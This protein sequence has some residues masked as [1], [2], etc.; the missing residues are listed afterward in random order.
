MAKQE[1]K[2]E[3]GFWGDR[4]EVIYED[5]KKIGETRHETNLFG[6]PRDRTYDTSGNRVSETITKDTFFSGPVSK[7]YDSS[8]N[9]VS[10]TRQENTFFGQRTVIVENGQKIGE[11]KRTSTFIDSLSGYNGR[12][13]IESY[14]DRSINPLTRTASEDNSSPSTGSSSSSYYSSGTRDTSVARREF[15]SEGVTPSPLDIVLSAKEQ[16]ERSNRRVWTKERLMLVLG[17]KKDLSFMVQE[18]KYLAQNSS[19]ELKE[20]VLSIA[21]SDIL[22]KSLLND[23]AV[24]T[25]NDLEKLSEPTLELII[26]QE[27]PKDLFEGAIQRV[28]GSSPSLARIVK[29]KSERIGKLAI[30]KMSYDALMSIVLDSPPYVVDYC[31]KKF[32][33]AVLMAVA[34]GSSNPFER[35]RAAKKLYP[36]SYLRQYLS[37]Q[38]KAGFEEV[39][40]GLLYALFKGR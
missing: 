19:G 20:A 6:Q 27:S 8:G 25:V 38:E 4:K 39:I 2:T 21:G 3:T 22:R 12:K 13:S 26:E 29:C 5:G 30:E 11:I 14:G 33:E 1:I 15:G 10:E 17:S 40:C 37:M 35:L 31:V 24:L 34:K 23:P 36:N 32:G 9:C 18:M 16:F 7:T 28:N